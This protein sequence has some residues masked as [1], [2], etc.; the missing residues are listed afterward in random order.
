MSLDTF[1]KYIFIAVNMPDLTSFHFR[2]PAKLRLE[3]NEDI[4]IMPLKR[5][6]SK[7]GS[8]ECLKA[9]E[10]KKNCSK[11]FKRV[12]FKQSKATPRFQG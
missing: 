1:C 6:G 10:G 5:L 8:R 12:S 3:K 2:S 7:I 4:S 9:Q 11:T